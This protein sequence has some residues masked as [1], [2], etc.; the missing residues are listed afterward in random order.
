LFQIPALQVVGLEGLFGFFAMTILL[1]PFYF[2]PAGNFG[3][4]PR[5][6]VEDAIHGFRQVPMLV[7]HQQN[8]QAFPASPE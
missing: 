4:T 5:F 1:F 6:V 2:I 3:V 8:L 7:C